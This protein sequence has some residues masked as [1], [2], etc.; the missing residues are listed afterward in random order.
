[1]PYD[2]KFFKAYAVQY[3]PLTLTAERSS[4]LTLQVPLA[5]AIMHKIKHPF[6]NVVRILQWYIFVNLFGSPKLWWDLYDVNTA[7]VCIMPFWLV[8]C[9]PW[10]WP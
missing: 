5:F 4:D 6:F 2:R 10:H 3:L 9:Q 7:S 1:M 8:M